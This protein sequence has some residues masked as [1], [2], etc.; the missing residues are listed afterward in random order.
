MTEQPS[1]RYGDARIT[2]SIRTR[3]KDNGKVLIKVHA[4]GSVVAH[5]PFPLCQ[6]TVASP[7]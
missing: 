4:D 6:T 7:E 1:I 3:P 2:Y 5:A